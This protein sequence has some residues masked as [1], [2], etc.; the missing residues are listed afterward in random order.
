[1]RLPIAIFAFGI[2]LAA[3]LP[4]RAEDLQGDRFITALKDNTVSGKTAAGTA[5]NL[6]FLEGGT[7]TY[8]DA[9]GRRVGGHWQLDR[10]GDV[11]VTWQSETAFPTGCYRV[12]TDGSSIA[13]SSKDR[14]SDQTLRGS[15][16]NAFLTAH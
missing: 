3:A 10:S 5:Y 6:Y 13:W 4:A 1:M 16:T 2:A 14:S 15:V 8:G 11:C 12:Q 9:S 7:A